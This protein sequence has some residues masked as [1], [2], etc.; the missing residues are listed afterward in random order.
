MKA[1]C[2]AAVFDLDGTLLDTCADLAAS[3]N[4]VLAGFGLPTHPAEDYRAFIGNG[5]RMLVTRAL[6]TTAATPAL[7]D[8]CLAAFRSDY[9]LHWADATAPF[10]GIVDMLARLQEKNIPAAVLTNKPH[11]AAL[12]CVAR[13]FPDFRFAMIAGE[14]PGRPPKPDP[15]GAM[16]VAKVLG[17]DPAEVLY[18]GDMTVDMTL[19]KRAGFVAAAALW[20]YQSREQLEEAGAEIFL[21]APGEIAG[22]FDC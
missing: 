19:A 17:V 6:G 5:A 12:A 18:V 14:I 16:E 4:R 13:F 22:L 15:A 2:R 7:V 1:S 20:G 3:V 21:E 9:A 11:E 10:P 8:D